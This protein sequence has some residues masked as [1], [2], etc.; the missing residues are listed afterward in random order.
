MSA[1][2]A[3][4]PYVEQLFDDNEIQRQLSRA[5]ANLRAASARASKAKRKRDVL[6]DPRIRRRLL[7][8]DD[9]TGS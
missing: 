9:P 4:Q 3:V 6:Q 2:E 5:G 8:N 7:G 1:L